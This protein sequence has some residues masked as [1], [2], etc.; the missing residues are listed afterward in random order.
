M[1]HRPYMHIEKLG[2]EE[3]DGILVGD[4]H[5]FPKL[6]GSNGLVWLDDDGM[7]CGSRKRHLT[8]NTEDNAGFREYIMWQ[9]NILEYL[10]K[11]PTHILYG[12]WLVSHTLKTYRDDMWREF[13][14]FDVYS[15]SQECYIPYD[16]YCEELSHCGIKFIPRIVEIKNPTE[17]KL[18]QIMQENRWSIKDGEGIGEGIVIK[19]YDFANRYER[20][21]WAKLVSTDFKDKHIKAM[22]EPKMEM[23]PVECQM[24]AKLPQD[25][26]DKVYANLVA[27]NDNMWANSLIPR[28]ISTVWHDFITEELWTLIKKFKNPTVNFRLLQHHVTARLKELKPEAF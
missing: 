9:A 15:T 2:R 10:H 4:C 19:N 6:D 28:L 16:D 26:V 22:G 27:K 8:D 7:Q 5:I 17:E 20:T 14:V 12:E 11:F 13:Y 23:N 24:A 25:L 1:E 21:T 3:V 18:T